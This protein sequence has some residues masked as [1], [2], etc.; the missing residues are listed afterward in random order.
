M[1]NYIVSLIITI[2]YDIIILYQRYKYKDIDTN[3]EDILTFI[4]LQ[5]VY[6]KENH[7]RL[8]PKYIIIYQI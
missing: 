3:H 6:I 7:E 1:V 4:L 5:K 2:Q 8:P